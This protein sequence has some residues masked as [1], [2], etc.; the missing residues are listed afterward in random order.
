[1]KLF[2]LSLILAGSLAIVACDNN[3]KPVIKNPLAGHVEAIEKAKD[4]ERQLQESLNQ[5]MKKIDGL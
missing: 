2:N 4:L 1:M 3:Q 5:K